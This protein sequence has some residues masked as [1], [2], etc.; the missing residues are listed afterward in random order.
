M[1]YRDTFDRY[2]FDKDEFDQF[3]RDK[4]DGDKLHRDSLEIRRMKREGRKRDYGATTKNKNPDTV[5]S[6]ERPTRII[7]CLAKSMVRFLSVHQFEKNRFDIEIIF[8][9]TTSHL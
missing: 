8:F 4:F 1:I 7:A 2:R 5:I 6:E 3:D 9:G